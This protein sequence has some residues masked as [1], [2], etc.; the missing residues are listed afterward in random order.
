MKRLVARGR[1]FRTQGQG[2][3]RRHRFLQGRHGHFDLQQALLVD[4]HGEIEFPFRQITEGP[5]EDEIGGVGDIV[6]DVDMAEESRELKV[7]S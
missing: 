6:V 5:L 2:E 7:E 4:A 1:V 3:R